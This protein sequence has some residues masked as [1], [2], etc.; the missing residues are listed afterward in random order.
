MTIWKPVDDILKWYND[1]HSLI[2]VPIS[3]DVLREKMEEMAVVDRVIWEEVGCETEHV[4]AQVTFHKAALGL[5]AG[6]GDYARIQYVESQNLC[7]RRFIMCKEMYQCILDDTQEKRTINTAQ[8]ITLIDNL[9]SDLVDVLAN[10]DEDDGRQAYNTELFAEIF[11]IETLFPYELRRTFFGDYDENKI[12]DYQ[13]AVRF[14]VP[15][16]IV[17]EAMTNATYSSAIA[18]G[19]A[20][21]DI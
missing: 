8:V 19:R 13:L 2:K 17:K 7:W 3:I 5:Y 20:L 1:T 6:T 10:E 12:T 15:Q 14:R 11:A 18:R 21:V 9:S 16:D 4:I